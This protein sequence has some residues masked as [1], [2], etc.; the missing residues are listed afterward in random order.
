MS[1]LVS[2]GFEDDRGLSATMF[3][4]RDLQD[5]RVRVFDQHWW[6]NILE[7]SRRDQLGF[8]AA[9]WATGVPI[10]HL[11]VDWRLPNELF[12]RT[13]HRNSVRRSVS[14]AARQGVD[15]PT[16]FNLS[17]LPDAYPNPPYWQEQWTSDALAL[18]RELN[19]V[20]VGT[21]EPLEGNY[22]HMHHAEVGRW[23]PPDPRRSWKREF[24]RQA[25]TGLRTFLEVGFNAGH[26]AA[27]A[28][29]ENPDLELTVVDIA[30]HGYTR[31]CAQVLANAF[32]GRVKCR[33]GDSRSLL[34]RSR[35]FRATTFDLVHVDGGH[36]EEVFRHDLDWWLST[37]QPGCRLLVDD[38]YVAHIR[39]LLED[40][41]AGGEIREAAAGLPSSGENRLFVRT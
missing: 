35:G 31:E 14:S 37:S 11:D 27:I 32:P 8:E 15:K 25:V 23:T 36:G 3:L 19:T 28:L 1:K 34:R 5:P 13:E 17:G 9:S 4:I 6:S 20:V 41:L 24:L 30:E 33:W 38:A 21:G 12:L 22:C 10:R 7:G 39:G 16:R 26:S 40:A 2:S 29:S 18:I